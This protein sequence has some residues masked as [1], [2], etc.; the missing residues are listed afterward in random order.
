MVVLFVM[1]ERVERA[2]L[3]QGRCTWWHPV[4][5]RPFPR[6]EMGERSSDAAYH[7]VEGEGSRM[8]RVT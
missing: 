2:Y 3:Y 6:V 4:F 1:V 7:V 8:D 5:P